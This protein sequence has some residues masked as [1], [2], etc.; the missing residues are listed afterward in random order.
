MVLTLRVR[1]CTKC[2]EYIVIHPNNPI[3]QIF[4]NTFEEFH[5]GHPLITIDL[6]EV[7]ENMINI[8]SSILEFIEN[9]DKKLLPRTSI[10]GQIQ[11]VGK[12]KFL[13]VMSYTIKSQKSS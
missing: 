13:S 2:E 9:S 12:G 1:A 8:S 11:K 10:R 4:V 3:S 5:K 6:N 7:K